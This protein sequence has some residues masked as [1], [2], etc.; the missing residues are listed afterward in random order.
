MNIL[1]SGILRTSRALYLKTNT[2]SIALYQHA[3]GTGSIRR[4]ERGTPPT[5]RCRPRTCFE[6]P[7]YSYTS[8]VTTKALITVVYFRELFVLLPEINYP[9]FR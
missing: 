6:Y 2:R 9:Q 3:P 8:F 4:T 7:Q 1:K 5:P